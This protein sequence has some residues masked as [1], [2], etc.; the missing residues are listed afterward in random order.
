MDDCE[1]FSFNEAEFRLEVQHDAQGRKMLSLFRG[2]RP[3]KGVLNPTLELLHYMVLRPKDVLPTPDL[4]NQLW[5][6]SDDNIVQKHIKSLRDVLGDDPQEPY[7]IETL[8]GRGYRFLLPVARRGGG[9][10]AY[11]KWERARFYELM[12][13]LK[14][15]PESDEEDLRIVATAI[16]ASLE[17]VDFKGLL[18][19]HLRIKVLFINQA[20]AALV[21]ARYALRQDKP[22]ARLIRDLNEQTADLRKLALAHPPED[23]KREKTIKDQGERG[24]LE[25]GLSDNMP[26]GFLLHT[27]DWAILA[28][29]PAHDSYTEGPM[30]EIHS[31]S[32]AWETLHNDWK[33]RWSNFEEQRATQ[34]QRVT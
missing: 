6:E 18:R 29:Y 5:P 28:V 24:S 14:R 12:R 19:R 11:A 4:I 21:H 2:D 9:I 3:I 16:G 32:D 7:Y 23:H 26:C 34:E 25:F 30:L 1:I 27:K 15:G 22:V 13:D 8:R 33:A 17:E 31:S 10:K 20:N